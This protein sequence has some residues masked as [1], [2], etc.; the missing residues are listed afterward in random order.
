MVIAVQENG[1]RCP[2]IAGMEDISV[3]EVLRLRDCV[4]TNKPYPLRSFREDLPRDIPVSLSDKEMKQQ[5][6]HG[7]RLVCRLLNI[8]E[9]KATGTSANPTS[10]TI[11]QLYAREADINEKATP[12]QGPGAS[13]FDCIALDEDDSEGEIEPVLG[14]KRSRPSSNTPR[15]RLAPVPTKQGQYTFGDMFCG[16]GGSSQG[17]LQAGLQVRWG[18]DADDDAIEAYQSNHMGALPFR[19]NAHNF[20]PP[21]TTVE[22]L[23]VDVLHLSPPCCYFS[24]AQ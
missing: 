1:T 7:G 6:F 18:L 16:A 8:L 4:L 20:P 17:A 3:D 5:I 2:M 9:F 13:R 24:P 23:R 14:K 22:E 19:C 12:S 11:R 21:G 10:G 15:K